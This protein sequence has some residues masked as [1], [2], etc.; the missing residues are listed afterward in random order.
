M[1]DMKALI[2]ELADWDRNCY[3]L[4]GGN[5]INLL[6]SHDL[7]SAEDAERMYREA[8]RELGDDTEWPPAL[9]VGVGPDGPVSEAMFPPR[10]IEDDKIPF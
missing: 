5:M 4:G 9:F 7:V 1:A 3:P 6:V 2:K 10:E 8:M